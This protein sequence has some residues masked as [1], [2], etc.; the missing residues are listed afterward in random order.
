M[1][2]LDV[3]TVPQDQLPELLGELARLQAEALARLHTRVDVPTVENPPLG[4]VLTATEVAELFKVSERWVRNHRAE[5]GGFGTAKM[6][7]FPEQGV[8]AWMRQAQ[9]S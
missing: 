6:L 7:R 1:I 8:R 3:E 4:T 2:K 5:L 9:K